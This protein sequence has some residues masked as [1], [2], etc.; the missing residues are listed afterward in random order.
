MSKSG[1]F[2]GFFRYKNI[3]S[4][5]VYGITALVLFMFQYIPTLLPRIGNA[6]PLPLLIFVVCVSVF[7]GA[8]AGAVMGILSG[9]LWG[10]YSSHVFGFDALILMIIGIACG[11]LVEWLMRANFLTTCILCFSAILFQLLCDWFFC[12]VLFG[13]PNKL[14]M[15]WRMYLPNGLYTL[16]LTPLMFVLIRFIARKIRK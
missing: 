4:W 15:L 8:R 16:C 6:R 7:E 9:L 2:F 11:L 3:R 12:H 10:L 1:T 14:E 13:A 5:V